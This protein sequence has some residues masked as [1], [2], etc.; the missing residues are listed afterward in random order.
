M[1][2]DLIIYIPINVPITGRRPLKEGARLCGHVMEYNFIP[3]YTLV[4]IHIGH[5]Y[6]IRYLIADM[7]IVVLA[8][9]ILP[10][11]YDRRAP[12]FQE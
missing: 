5:I 8:G 6:P 11:S 12:K 4:V 10:S 1:I 2:Y 3:N 9:L 7:T